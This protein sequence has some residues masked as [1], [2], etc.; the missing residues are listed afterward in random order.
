MGP[1]T[2]VLCDRLE[3]TIQLLDSAKASFWAVWLRNALNL[4]QAG[5]Y[6]G[7]EHLQRAYGGM[8]SF[9]DLVLAAIN[10]RQVSDK[11]RE[12]INRKLDNLRTELYELVEFIRH[13]A[14]TT[15]P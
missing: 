8:G 10:G 9:N 7:I 2:T 13:N 3:E 5:D 14:D 12:A 15:G 1:K 6:A 11:D 4:I